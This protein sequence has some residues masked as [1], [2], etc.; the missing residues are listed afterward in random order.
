MQTG[1]P[2]PESLVQRTTQALHEL[3]G[4][5]R[6]GDTLP[7]EPRLA[8]ELK[9]SRGTLRKALDSLATEGRISASQPGSRRRISEAFRNSDTKPMRSVAVLIPKP[10]D[11]TDALTLAFLRELVAV[12]EADGITVAVHHS[13]ATHRKHPAKLLE[14]LVR[15]QPADL[16]LLYEASIP[17]AGFFRAEKIPAVVC[18]GAGAA[19]GLPVCAFDGAAALRHA[20]GVLIRAGHTRIVAASRYHRPLRERVFREE[21]ERRGLQFDRSRH[22]PLWSDPGQLHQLLCTRL[23]GPESPTAWIINGMEGLIV[24]FST[25]LELGLRIPNDVSLLTFGSDPMLG[26]FRPAVAHYSTPHRTLAVAVAKMIRSHFESQSNA[27]DSKLIQTVYVPGGS[28]GP[29]P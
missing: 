16:W 23:R 14:T 18:G 3:I 26:C 25:M 21:F 28:V 8:R 13:A 10:L 15:E 7:G 2:R 9:V 20:L 1:V 17:V 12:T 5:G 6:Y 29:A 19:E 11:V 27:A 22:M 24:F 4:R